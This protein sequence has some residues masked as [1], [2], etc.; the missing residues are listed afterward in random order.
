V[1]ISSEGDEKVW[2]EA[3]G[4]LSAACPVPWVLLSASAEYKIYLQMVTVACQSGAAGVA[5]GR[6]VWQE[7]TQ[8]DGIKRKQ[9]LEEVAVDR[10][11][12]LTALCDALARPWMEFYAADRSSSSSY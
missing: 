11:Q 8:L 3:C 1:D 2:A 4:E 7:A 10:M 12:R 6:A 9:F 5:A